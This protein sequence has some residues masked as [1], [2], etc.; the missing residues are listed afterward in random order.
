MIRFLFLVMSLI[1]VACGE[2]TITQTDFSK[3]KTVESMLEHPESVVL[4]KDILYVSNLGKNL[5]PTEKDGD[6]FITKINLSG[7][8]LEKNFL[9]KN[10]GLNA[11]KGMVIK[12]GILYVTDVDRVL[13]FEIATKKKLYEV[14]FGHLG[15]SFL[16]DIALGEKNIL[17]VSATDKN[18]IFQLDVNNPKH[19]VPFAV[20]TIPGPNGLAYDKDT[21]RL[22]V[23]S[24]GTNGGSNGEIGYIDLSNDK[25]NYVKLYG[26][27]MFDGIALHHGHLIV[28]DWA[29]KDNSLKVFDIEKSEIRP[30]NPDKAIIVQGSADFISDSIQKNLLLPAMIDGKLFLEKIL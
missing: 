29:D 7:E 30:L 22:Y 17:F 1:L 9:G 5:T 27:G 13:G 26:T 21:A 11:P 19:I 6:G 24:F 25:K 28:S 16:N 14:T 12:D 15:I 18:L 20:T 2:D 3:F 10:V 4:D 8:V 23:A